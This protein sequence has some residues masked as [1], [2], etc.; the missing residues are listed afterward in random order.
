M[1]TQPNGRVHLGGP[2][3]VWDQGVPTAGDVWRGE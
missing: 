3:D 1:G 2:Y